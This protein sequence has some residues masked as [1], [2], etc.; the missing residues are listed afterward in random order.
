[1]NVAI[2]RAREWRVIVGNHTYFAT[3]SSMKDPMLRNLAKHHSGCKQKPR[4][5][6]NECGLKDNWKYPSIRFT[7]EICDN[8]WGPWNEGTLSNCNTNDGRID[9]ESL[10][11]EYNLSESL[12]EIYFPVVSVAVFGIQTVS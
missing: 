11:M 7:N 10:M 9:K 1:M 3:D 6:Y 4:G 2:T 12:L 5:I 8:I